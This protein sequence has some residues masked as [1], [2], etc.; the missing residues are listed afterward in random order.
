M[1]C[2]E[3]MRNISN[4]PQIISLVVTRLIG[5]L[6]TVGALVML[7]SLVAVIGETLPGESNAALYGVR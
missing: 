1:F 2:M 7:E 6:M 3:S 5:S 4:G